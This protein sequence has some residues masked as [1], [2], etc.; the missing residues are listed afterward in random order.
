MP[1][2]NKE[3]VEGAADLDEDTIDDA[4]QLAGH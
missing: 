2:A 4:A 1:D 3:A